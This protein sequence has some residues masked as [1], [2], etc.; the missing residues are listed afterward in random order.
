MRNATYG[1]ALT[2]M[3]GWLIWIGKPVLI[4]V[5]AAA[6]SVYVLSTAAESMQALPVVG[7]LPAWARR[8]LILIA[9]V[10]AVVLLFILVINNLAQVAAV[11]PRY[12][13]NLQI[14][15]TRSASLLGI[16]DE[17]TWENLR[18][19]TLDQM[20]IRSWIAPALLSLRGFGATL[21]LVVLYA[22]FFM[23]ERGMMTRKVVIALGGEEAGG[24][25]LTL[26]SR[27][28]ERIGQYLFVK[29][30][31]NLILGSV[32]FVIMLVLGIE[33]ALF[34][35]V[36][37]AFLNYIPYIGSL[38]GVIFPVL[39]SLAQFGTL[40]MAGVVLLSLSAAQIFVGAVLEPRMMGR[41]FN[42][43]PLVVLLALAVWSTLWGLPGA[44][45]AVPM[46]ASLILVLAE[47]RTTRPV[48]VLLSASGKV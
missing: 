9:F 35:A 10:F 42:L 21:F 46:T 43:S 41:A 26:L 48:A 29:T 3:I 22:S 27:I 28:N 30:V 31:V 39:L 45:L 8:T 16:E 6:I 32:S 37:I 38:V 47:I 14:L 40:W 19:V 12:E 11:L 18:R 24:R 1:L 34:W 13:T 36:L 20:D 2:L 25:A 33:F 44:L 7:R 4:P 17:P 5:I 23:A 15:V